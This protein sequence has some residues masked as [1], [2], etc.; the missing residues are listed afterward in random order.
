MSVRVLSAEYPNSLNAS[1]VKNK[2]HRSL[3]R[4]ANTSSDLQIKENNKSV[5]FLTK[6]CGLEE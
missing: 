1:S 5:D 6:P 3:C 4:Q 2:G